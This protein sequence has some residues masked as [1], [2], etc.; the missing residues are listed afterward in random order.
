MCGSE[1]S[2]ESRQDTKDLL[3]TK[4]DE[5]EATVGKRGLSQLFV[6]S[7]NMSVGE[8][9]YEKLVNVKFKNLPVH[10]N[11]PLILTNLIAYNLR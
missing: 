6:G 3:W 8:E 2:K 10:S 9:H 4:I 7:N 5:I 11:V 1:Q